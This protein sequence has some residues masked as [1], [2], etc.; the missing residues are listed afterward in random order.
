VLVHGFSSPP[1][2]LLDRPLTAGTLPPDQEWMEDDSLLVV[3]LA[4]AT[5]LT[6]SA[7][8]ASLV[9]TQV[10]FAEGSVGITAVVEGEN[11]GALVAAAPYPTAE[12]LL[13]G[14][15]QAPLPT[16][17]LRAHRIEDVLVLRD[18]AV[19]WLSE[20]P[21][22]WAGKVNVMVMQ[23][24]L[25]QVQQIML[26]FKLL[27][28]SITGIAL[29]VGGVGIMNVLLAAVVERTRE[30]GIRKAVGARQV[31]IV[32]QFLSESVTIAVMGSTVGIVLGL[33]AAAA[34]SA[35]MRHQTDAP[36]YPVVS[37]GSIAIA[38][39]AAIL[40]GLIFGTYPALRAGRLDPIDALRHD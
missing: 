9:G 26:L 21:G 28:G 18:S 40:I 10:T 11:N 32:T 39:A 3:S 13:A 35:V 12:R 20:Q 38:A 15:P 25:A 16:M 5:L 8:P 4:L 31:H 23:T 1:A 30:I 33:S 24:R 17:L 27:M 34:A 19:A 22:N 7:P 2:A 36:V 6:D 14:H 37:V 29:V